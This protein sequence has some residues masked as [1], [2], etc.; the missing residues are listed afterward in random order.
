MRNFS[1]FLYSANETFVTHEAAAER[2]Y[3][4]DLSLKICAFK[5]IYIVK[6]L[7]TLYCKL[8]ISQIGD[9]KRFSTAQ[10]PCH[11]ALF[12]FVRN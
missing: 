6:V 4:I 7:I 8:C 11:F 2:K 1:E 9:P 3:K 5:I 10:V 12:I